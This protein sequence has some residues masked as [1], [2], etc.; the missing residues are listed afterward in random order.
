M[1][2]SLRQ[3]LVHLD[4]TRTL[5]D[6]LAMARQI[7]E[8]QGAVLSALYAAMPAFVELPYAPE[9]GPTLAAD[10]AALDEERRASALRIFDQAMSTPGP[11]ATWSQTNV[12]PVVGAFAQQAL[13]A[14]LLVLGQ[15][16]GGAPAGRAVPSDF[17]EAVLMASGR[18]GV[19]VPFGGWSGTVGD[20]VAIAWKETREAAH[21]VSAAIPFLQRAAQVHVLAWGEE[22]GATIGGQQLDLDGYLRLHG[23]EGTWHRGGPEPDNVGELLLSSVFDLR[24]DLL[25][26]GCYGHSRAREWV[27]GGAS[28]S[29]LHSMTLPVLMAH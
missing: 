16:D 12:E 7:A 20:T 24:A 9:V 15:H 13:F 18:P 21:A 26:M 6:R 5:A 27:L 14:D 11:M 17:V 29:V 3:V 28:R 25:V 19:V 2:S 22:G 1:A 4:A 8:Q 10:L 23:V